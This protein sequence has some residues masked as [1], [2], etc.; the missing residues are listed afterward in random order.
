MG[1]LVSREQLQRVTGYMSQG[2]EAGACYVTGGGRKGGE[3][4]PDRYTSDLIFL[5]DAS[6]AKPHSLDPL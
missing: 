2:K 4:L 6:M 3:G 5:Q 1:P